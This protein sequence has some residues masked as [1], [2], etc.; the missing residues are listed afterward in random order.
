MSICDLR[1]LLLGNRRSDQPC[2]GQTTHVL[3]IMNIVYIQE[4]PMVNIY[5]WS[6]RGLLYTDKEMHKE[7]YSNT[8]SPN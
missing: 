3:C 7:S 2:I 4:G 1:I 8:P 6:T 5:I